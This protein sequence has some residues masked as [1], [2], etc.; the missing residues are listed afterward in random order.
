MCT[1]FIYFD[2]FLDNIYIFLIANA[3]RTIHSVL[4]VIFCS[5]TFSPTQL[6]KERNKITWKYENEKFVRKEKQ[7]NKNIRSALSQFLM[8]RTKTPSEDTVSLSEAMGHSICQRFIL[9][10]IEFVRYYI[11]FMLEFIHLNYF[12]I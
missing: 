2:F 5:N 9:Y 10:C 7:L 8:G 6:Q 4:F 3:A 11:I 1:E 12:Y